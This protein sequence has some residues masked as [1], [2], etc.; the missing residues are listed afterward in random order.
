M[1]GSGD[2]IGAGGGCGGEWRGMNVSDEKGNCSTVRLDC[3]GRREAEE[4]GFGW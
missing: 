1:A 4:K 3:G 2:E